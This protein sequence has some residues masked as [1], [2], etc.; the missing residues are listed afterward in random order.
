MPIRALVRP[1]VERA[2]S[3]LEVTI[4]SLVTRGFDNK[5]KVQWLEESETFAWLCPRDPRALPRGHEE[6]TLCPSAAFRAQ[7]EARITIK[8]NFSDD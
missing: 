4:K 5:V 1:S 6:R 7:T 2:E 8:R 3:G